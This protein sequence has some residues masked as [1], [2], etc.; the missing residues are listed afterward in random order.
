MR[1]K[2]YEKRHEGCVGPLPLDRFNELQLQIRP[3]HSKN[4]WLIHKILFGLALVCERDHHCDPTAANIHPLLLPPAFIIIF[5][6]LPPLIE[7]II[8]FILCECFHFGIA[9]HVGDGNKYI[10][11]LY[12]GRNESS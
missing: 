1:I 10:S 3:I 9:H 7:A 4:I 12:G 11:W 8:H 6:D 2:I 5:L